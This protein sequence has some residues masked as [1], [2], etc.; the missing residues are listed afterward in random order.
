MRKDDQ[1]TFPAPQALAS[2]AAV[3]S[4][5]NALWGSVWLVSH[6][7]PLGAAAYNRHAYVGQQ[8]GFVKAGT[9]GQPPDRIGGDPIAAGA[10]S[11][12]GRNRTGRRL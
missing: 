11:A 3:F 8:Q 1:E 7:Q 10:A 6:H 5:K 9:C 2:H 12:D 4:S